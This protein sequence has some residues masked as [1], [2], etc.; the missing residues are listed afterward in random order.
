M[1]L[2]CVDTGKCIL[3]ARIKQ[4]TSCWHTELVCNEA[5]HPIFR[6]QL[7]GLLDVLHPISVWW[8]TFYPIGTTLSKTFTITRTRLMFSYHSDPRFQYE[9]IFIPNKLRKF[10]KRLHHIQLDFDY[11]LLCL[12]IYKRKK[13]EWIL[14]FEP[15]SPISNTLYLPIEL[16]MNWWKAD[17]Y[18]YYHPIQN[19][20][21]FHVRMH[22]F[23]PRVR[24]CRFH[25][26]AQSGLAMERKNKPQPGQLPL[27]IAPTNL[28]CFVYFIP[29]FFS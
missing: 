10:A 20:T 14:R 19:P 9:L 28:S 5:F 18:N 22:W 1:N 4:V 16:I 15:S 17:L 29:Y 2:L 13:T 25:S 11:L 8:V 24:M 7:S 26:R 12:T 6:Y 27:T 21:G 3:K 23:P